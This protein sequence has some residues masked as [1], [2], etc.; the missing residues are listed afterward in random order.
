[1]R[2]AYA[3]AVA[4][5]RRDVSAHIAASHS[6]LA[7]IKADQVWFVLM[8]WCRFSLDEFLKLEKHIL[9]FSI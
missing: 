7:R 9:I 8:G 6:R 3:D 2:R 1:M 5:I 4:S